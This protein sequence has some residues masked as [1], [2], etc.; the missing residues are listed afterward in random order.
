M[1]QY[2]CIDSHGSWAHS[3]V[4]IITYAVMKTYPLSGVW[5]GALIYS[6]DKQDAVMEAIAEYQKTGQLDRK[7]AMMTYVAVNND[8]IILSLAYL[9]AVVKPAAFSAFYNITPLLDTTAIQ[10][11]FVSVLNIPEG[12]GLPPP[13]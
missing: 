4:G 1:V 12:A 3:C 10:P 13:R 7:S 5:G 6:G 11:N 2:L 9:D 8:T